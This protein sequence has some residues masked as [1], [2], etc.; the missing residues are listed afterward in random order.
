[1]KPSGAVLMVC[2]GDTADLINGVAN[3]GVTTTFEL[4][5]CRKVVSAFTFVFVVL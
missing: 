4:N 5:I 3:S 1:M 2:A